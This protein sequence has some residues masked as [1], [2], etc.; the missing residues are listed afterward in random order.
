L[1]VAWNVALVEPAATVA[2]AGTVTELLL[3]EI[4]ITAPPVGAACDSDTVQEDDAPDVSEVG[5]H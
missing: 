3:S 2:D 4:V 1:A 5:E